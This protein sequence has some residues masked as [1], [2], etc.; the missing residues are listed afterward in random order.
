[1]TQIDPPKSSIRILKANSIAQQ[2]I[3]TV[4]RPV[5]PSRLPPFLVFTHQ[6]A[7]GGMT[8]Y[9]V[10]EFP[11]PSIS[12]ASDFSPDPISQ[13]QFT[14]DVDVSPNGQFTAFANFSDPGMLVLYDGDGNILP[15]PSVLPPDR[16]TIVKFSRDSSM[17][18]IVSRDSTLTVYSTV[19]FSVVTQF[20]LPAPIAGF[21]ARDISWSMND[22]IVCI[23]RSNADDSEFFCV[24]YDTSTW[25]L[26]PFDTGVAPN[27]ASGV[28]FHPTEDTLTVVSGSSITIFDAS[29]NPITQTAAGI[30]AT[31]QQPSQA[32]GCE[33]NSDGSVFVVSSADELGSARTLMGY[34]TTSLPYQKLADPAVLP[35]ET[36][37]S[38]TSRVEWTS[39]DRYVAV[40]S[41]VSPFLQVFDTTTSPWTNITSRF[42]ETPPEATRGLAFSPI[43]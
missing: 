14:S 9:N 35:P 11:D 2:N 7:G 38:T 25:T 32:R 4:R 6:L 12:T 22:G 10:S 42:T 31:N 8:R 37:I 34:T 23:G 3:T 40:S 41:D 29:V 16:G 20:V 27:S 33:Y 1:M 24:V 18:A 39:D 43:S 13:G 30:N 17:L 21:G 28:A 15:A 5:L 36:S 19:D 26:I